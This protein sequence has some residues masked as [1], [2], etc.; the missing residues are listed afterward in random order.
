MIIPNSKNR[1]KAKDFK[2]SMC[3]NDIQ[4]IDSVKYLGLKI[5]NNLNSNHHVNYVYNKVAQAAGIVQRWVESL[6]YDSTPT[7]TNSSPTPFRLR[8]FFL[9]HTPTPKFSKFGN[10]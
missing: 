1:N 3:G 2:I 9:C 4:Q 5:Q 7:P 8:K 6:I 10:Q